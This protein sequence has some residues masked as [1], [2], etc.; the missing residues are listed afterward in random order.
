M[1]TKTV[2]ITGC[3]QGIGLEFVKHYVAQGWKVIATARNPS[4]SE[5]LQNSG[6]ALIET[7]DVTN[8]ESITQLVERMKAE[9]IDMLINNAGYLVVDNLNDAKKE[10][11]VN[12][13]VTNSV[14]PFLVTRALLPNLKTAA[15][16]NGPSVVVNMTSRMGSVEDNTS[17][18]MYG[19]RASKAAF[20]A[21]SKSLAVDLKE[22]GIISAIL[23]PGFVQTNMTKGAGGLTPVQAVQALAKVIDT[24]DMS[25][26]GIFYHSDGHVLPW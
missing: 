15:Q 7:L 2:L 4:K 23:H 22:F 19:Y 11:I 8:D 21:I 14:A 24:L 16:A 17:G 12:Q 9:P 13:F 10:D 26:S 1:A 6:A 20:N 25:K 3:S 5:A 18:G